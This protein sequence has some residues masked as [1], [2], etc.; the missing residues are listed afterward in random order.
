TA[1]SHPFLVQSQDVGI[2]RERAALTYLAKDIHERGELA[3]KF[4][5]HIAERHV[6]TARKR[7]VRA[8]PKLNVVVDVDETARQA[9]G[10]KARDEE[11]EITDFAKPIALDAAARLQCA[12]EPD[13][14]RFVGGSGRRSIEMHETGKQVYK[15]ERGE[16]AH[17]DMLM[18]HRRFDEFLEVFR[19]RFV[20]NKRVGHVPP[21]TGAG[22]ARRLRARGVPSEFLGEIERNYN[23][24]QTRCPVPSATRVSRADRVPLCIRSSVPSA[25]ARSASQKFSVPMTAST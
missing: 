9:V 5:E 7:T 17:G 13:A 25:A 11:R 8:L 3:G 16:I 2:R 12:R 10:E 19:R 23:S 1:R 21:Y 15:I 24:K 20:S 22:L 14:K 6:S 4:V 18:L